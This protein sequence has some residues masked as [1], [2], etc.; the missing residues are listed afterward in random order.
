MLSENKII[1]TIKNNNFNLLGQIQISEEEYKELID[2]SKRIIR[3]MS[4][5]IG[6]RKNVI[7]SLALVHIAIR[8][9]KEGRFWPCFC[10]VIGEKVSSSK[11]NYCGKI[12]AITVKE[13]GLLYVSKEDYSSQM[14]VENIKMHAM[15]MNYYMEGFWEFLSSYYEKNLFR[16]ISDDLFE[17]IELLSEFM[18][19]TL[20]NNSDSFV[21]EESKGHAAKSY[22]LLKGTRCFFAYSN[23]DTI[24]SSLK[25][26]LRYIDVYYYDSEYPDSNNRYAESFIRWCKKRETKEK[27]AERQNRNRLIA[28]KRP[29]IHFDFDN[30][31]QYL[32]I[33]SQKFRDNECEGEA[34]VEISINGFTKTIDLDIYRSFGL[35]I[36]EIVKVPIPSVFDDISIIIKS[37]VI[38][39][40][41][42]LSSNYRI[43]NKNNDF[44]YKI[45][46]GDNLLLIKK[47]TNVSYEGRTTIVDYSNEYGGFDLY[48]LKITDDSIIHIGKRKISIL[49]EYSEIPYF[50]EEISHFE[51]FDLNENKLVVT[52]SHPTISFM[53]HERKISGTVLIVNE[54]KYS[55][56]KVDKIIGYSTINIKDKAIT[57]DLERV[58]PSIDGTY[59]VYIDIPDDRNIY[60]SKYVRINKMDFSFNKGLYS[61]DDSIYLWI[62]NRCDSIWPDREDISLVSI[63]DD[64]DEY[65]IPFVE[66][67]NEVYFHL[68]LNEKLLIKLPINILKFGFSK[69]ELTCHQPEFIWYSDLKETIYCSAPNMSEIRVYINHEK[70]KYV[71]GFSI[72]SGLFRVDIS[73]LKQRICK[74]IY[75]GWT[76]LNI[77]CI[78]TKKY[79]YPLY[80]VLRVLWVEPYFDFVLVDGKLGFD[81]ELYGKA[82][83]LIDIEDEYTKEKI[84]K[85]KVI[86][87]GVNVFPELP[88][89]GVYNIIPKMIEEDEFGL[90]KRSLKMRALF[91]QSYI[92]LDN[93]T[94]C[95]LSVADLLYFEEEK[96]L[97]YEYR[98]DIRKKVDMCTFEGYMHGLKRKKTRYD[99]TEDKRIPDKKKLGKVQIKI[100]EESDK[101]IYIQI[102]S[103]TY[104]QNP[105][106]WIEFYYDDKYNT[107][108]HSNDNVLRQCDSYERFIFLADDETK[109]RVMKKKIRRLKIN[110]I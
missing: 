78:G 53:V 75:N 80:S 30:M 6:A 74:N 62:N 108:L 25:P 99:L 107:L 16:Q 102:Y 70:E 34:S 28:S 20:S 27:S 52:R 12:F 73:E 85:D 24:I 101:C 110:D 48:V 69:D 13:L 7:F 68:E 31:M 90:N 86:N 92:D 76:Y 17:D 91:N 47:D 2:Y 60:I 41:R 79:S 45:A 95:R 109:Y 65:I 43:L 8:E 4:P 14:Y 89:D 29:Y 18:K 21:E 5:S 98:I 77:V 44:I 36:S 106:E 64:S 82:Q 59:N 33:P 19:K 67:E 50:E 42:I 22:K 72:G 38:K 105:E 88:L 39:K 103:S 51:V 87:N 66:N 81:V 9:Y 97:S 11:L 23:V 3:Y 57:I 54:K 10:D 104:E 71:K 100:I 1:E 26:L 96:K 35:Y 83:L 63:D 37:G 94:D 84:V 93:L 61:A 32:V 58:L 15:V 46:L 40:Y 49:G 55:L 56:D